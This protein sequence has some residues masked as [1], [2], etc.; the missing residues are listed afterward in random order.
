MTLFINRNT[1]IIVLLLISTAFEPVYAAKGARLTD[2]AVTNSQ[3]NLL[4]YLNVKGAF[5]EKIQKVIVSGVPTTFSFFITLDEVRTIWVNK[6]ISEQTLTHTI[7]YDS[8]KKTFTIR[9]SWKE[10]KPIIVK[11]LKQA[12]D[13]MT[14]IDA[15]SIIPLDKLEKGSRYRLSAK[16]KLSKMTLPFYLHYILM[17]ASKWEFETD[18][19]SIDFNY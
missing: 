16:A 15:F 6:N 5:T 13:L 7:K 10:E 2:L 3:N 14:R 18:W 4:V 12:R 19:H 8:L 11:S 9:R 1:I 17:M